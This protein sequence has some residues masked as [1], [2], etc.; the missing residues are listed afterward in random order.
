MVSHLID[1]Q[2]S[3]GCVHVMNV[4]NTITQFILEI[5]NRPS[6]QINQKQTSSNPPD[7]L[8]SSWTIPDSPDQVRTVTGQPGQLPDSLD[9]YRTVRTVTHPVLSIFDR[10]ARTGYRTAR[11]GSGQVTG[12]ATGQAPDRHRTVPDS[13]GQAGQPDSQGSGVCLCALHVGGIS[14]WTSSKYSSYV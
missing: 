9:S 6:P 12:Q 8:D 14:G 13:P 11:T 10:T 4:S 5:T 7:I 1:T 3:R 2:Q